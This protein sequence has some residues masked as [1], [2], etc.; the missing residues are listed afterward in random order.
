MVSLINI[1]LSLWLNDGQR[2]L[3]FLYLLTSYD[4]NELKDTKTT[5]FQN[6]KDT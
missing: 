4:P 3:Y 6:F 2:F 1:K 5:T